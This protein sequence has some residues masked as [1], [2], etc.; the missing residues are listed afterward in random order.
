MLIIND[1]LFDTEKIIKLSG[2][3]NWSSH[4]CLLITKCALDSLK[5][6]LKQ[7]TEGQSVILIIDCEKGTLPPIKIGIEIAKKFL[8]LKSTIS[9]TVNFTIIYAKTDE[10]K[11]WINKILSIYK[12][13]RPIYFLEHKADIKKALKLSK[14]GS[15]ID[16]N[17][18]IFSQLSVLDDAVSVKN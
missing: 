13:S 7:S 4:D 10:S 15:G 8:D 12:P 1:D 11:D 5:S 18:D 17:K 16:H 6:L 3:D 9:E 2:D 14:R